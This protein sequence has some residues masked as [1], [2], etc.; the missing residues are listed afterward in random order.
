[1]KKIV[2]FIKDKKLTVPAIIAAG[3]LS[4][5]AAS[6]VVIKVKADEVETTP[7]D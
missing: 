1:M 5:A 4:L 3:L 7:E 6:V 2:T